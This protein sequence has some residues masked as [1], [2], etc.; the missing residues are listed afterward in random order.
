MPKTIWDKRWERVW[1]REKPEVTYNQHFSKLKDPS[2][3]SRS[4]EFLAQQAREECA[5]M[6][7]LTQG[8]MTIEEIEEV[9]GLSQKTISATLKRLQGLV[10]WAGPM[11]WMLA[12]LE[13]VG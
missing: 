5:V 9:T 8:P 12:E 1:Y 13:K 7:A 4:H 2:D 10:Q 11:R 3:K 6:D